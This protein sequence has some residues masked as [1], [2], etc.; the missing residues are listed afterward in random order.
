MSGKDCSHAS[1]SR[2][3]GSSAGVACAAIGAEGVRESSSRASLGLSVGVVSCCCEDCGV[4]VPSGCRVPSAAGEGEEP[5]L[6]EPWGVPEGPGD[7]LP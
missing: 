1:A 6:G 2:I 3:E 5:G 4:P 7:G